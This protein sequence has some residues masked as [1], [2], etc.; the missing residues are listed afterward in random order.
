MRQ[1]I[2]TGATGYVGSQL[3]R[4]LVDE[5]YRLHVIVRRASNNAK[6][7]ALSDDAVIHESGGST[8]SIIKIFKAASP[9]LVFH[10]ASHVLGEHE[11]EDIEPLIQS[12]ILFG[13]QLLEASVA[14]GVEGFI[15]TGTFWQHYRG[16]SEYDPVCLY[17]ATKQ[18]FADIIVFYEGISSLRTVT[19][20]LFNVYG[21]ND[22]R[23]KLFSLLKEADQTGK[24]LSLSPGEQLLDLVY[25]DDV[26]EAYVQAA[27]LLISS[28]RWFSGRDFAVSSA[29][30]L[31]LRQVV[32][33]YERVLGRSLPVRWGGCPYRNREVMAPWQGACLPGWHAEVGLEEGL[34]RTIF[35]TRGA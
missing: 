29:E 27:R 25:I 3:A 18:A 17:A 32:A 4:R 26:I 6:L 35:A 21:P 14:C 5:G 30:R 20:K 10:V 12:N 23:K 1:A 15:N 31:S 2:M 9:E 11:P 8:E 24:T 19:L 7:A 13:A 16:K 22:K 33:T 34:R 28:E